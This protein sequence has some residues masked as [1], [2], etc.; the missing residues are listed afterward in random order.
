MNEFH[1]PIRLPIDSTAWLRAYCV[2]DAVQVQV[3]MAVALPSGVY[4][5][6]GG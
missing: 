1:P 3:K 4:G 2:P 5:L 6:G